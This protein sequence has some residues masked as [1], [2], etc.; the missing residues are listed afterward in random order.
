[1]N[2]KLAILMESR[3]SEDHGDG[4]LGGALFV[5]ASYAAFVVIAGCVAFFLLRMF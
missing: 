4:A 5:L 3:Q 2:P 1:M